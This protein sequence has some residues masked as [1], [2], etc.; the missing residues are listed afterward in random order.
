MFTKS[1]SIHPYV[2]TPKQLYTELL[3]NIRNI[4]KHRELPISLTLSNIHAIIDLA[5]LSCYYLDNKIIFVIKIP[6]VNRM[7]YNIYK[8]I[9]ITIPHDNKNPSSYAMIMPHCKHIAIS[10]DKNSYIC[11]NYIKDCLKSIDSN[12]ICKNLDILSKQNATICETEMLGK[13]V[14][15]LFLNNVKLKL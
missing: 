11:R 12:Y 10:K 3:S 6:L 13:I 4:A 2:L 9:S 1:H 7:E 8:P 14:N 5:Q 15:A